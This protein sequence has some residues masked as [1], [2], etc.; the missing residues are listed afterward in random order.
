MISGSG[1]SDN[2]TS[3]LANSYANAF[4]ADKMQK[5][6]TKG[7]GWLGAFFNWGE[8]SEKY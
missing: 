3:I 6:V 5:A 8:N 2:L 1:L 4:D 7:T